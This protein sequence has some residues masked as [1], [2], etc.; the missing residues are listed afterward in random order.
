L[1][2]NDIE[3][4]GIFS[5]VAAEVMR[6]YGYKKAIIMG[7]TLYSLGAIGF[8]VGIFALGKSDVI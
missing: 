3:L 5:P 7:L 2:N 1:T 4:T 6:R 8:W